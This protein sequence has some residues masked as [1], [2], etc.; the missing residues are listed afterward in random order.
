M[1]LQGRLMH[2]RWRVEMESH[3]YDW[4]C[5]PTDPSA[6][7]C[8]K[9]IGSMRKRTPFGH[10]RRCWRCKYYKY[11]PKARDAARRKAV[12]FDLD[13]AWSDVST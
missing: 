3:D 11:L 13:M 7:H 6:C 8:A 5:P 2:Q 12:E 4:R 9:G 10:S 1:A